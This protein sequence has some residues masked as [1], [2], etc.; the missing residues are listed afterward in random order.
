MGARI[1]SLQALTKE[2][3]GLDIPWMSYIE[4]VEM[5]DGICRVYGFSDESLASRSLSNGLC[6]WYSEGQLERI[7]GEDHYICRAVP[8]MASR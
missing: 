3:L 5:E 1:A 6:D 7:L 8:D 2:Q 4:D